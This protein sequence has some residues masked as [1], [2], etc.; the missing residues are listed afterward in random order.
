[1]A[2]VSKGRD[3][4]VRHITIVELANQYLPTVSLSFSGSY[5]SHTKRV[6]HILSDMRIR[7]TGELILTPEFV[8][9][10]LST[11][12]GSI[13][14]DPIRQKLKI[15]GKLRDFAAERRYLDSSESG[16][17]VALPPE[18]DDQHERF[19][20]ADRVL[21]PHYRH[22][23]DPDL[24]W[25]QFVLLVDHLKRG[26]RV[27][28]VA[29]LLA[30]VALIVLGRMS[31]QS[32][33]ELELTNVDQAG[34]DRRIRFARRSGRREILLSGPLATILDR[35][36]PRA[37]P[38]YL[39]PNQSRSGPLRIEANRSIVG[40]VNSQL[41]D[42]C[43]E[44]KI[45]TVRIE[46]L[47]RFGKSNIARLANDLESPFRLENGD[48]VLLSQP[49][50]IALLRDL[51]MGHYRDSKTRL[52]ER[53]AEYVFEIIAAMPEIA[54]TR[55]MESTDF[56]SRFSDRANI[57]HPGLRPENCLVDQLHVIYSICN[58]LGYMDSNPLGSHKCCMALKWEK[59]TPVYRRGTNAAGPISAPRDSATGED[60]SIDQA[61]TIT[62]DE[63]HALV[64]RPRP[65]IPWV[66]TQEQLEREIEAIESEACRD[67]VR[68]LIKLRPLKP[69]RTLLDKKSNHGD[70]VNLLRD[71]RDSGSRLG[72][73]LGFPGRGRK[74]VWI[75]IEI[76]D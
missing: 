73:A 9:C 35:W 59:R 58:D 69:T 75:E 28:I 27:W 21:A 68:A 4:L 76:I 15:L 43:H 1:M 37:G 6:L 5:L 11:W 47:R 61:A 42:A 66:G 62:Q 7:N 26:S 20:Q 12:G 55:D 67:V 14:R 65:P 63:S 17:P 56:V 64:D 50:S 32:A 8:D 57:A 70:S 38:K 40:S 36:W 41:A 39:I 16:R 49:I 46:G 44:V 31:A 74:G 13:K 23:P 52:T 34:P 33:S 19:A 29:R 72:R 22:L 2:T 18:W 45:P 51:V 10:F 71:L 53:M 24:T 30:L 54:T 3:G 25:E 60:K 48:G